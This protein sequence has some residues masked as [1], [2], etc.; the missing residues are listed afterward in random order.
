ML[1]IWSIGIDHLLLI[2]RLSTVIFR[3]NVDL[4]HPW[5]AGAART[6]TDL[7]AH[8]ATGDWVGDTVLVSQIFNDSLYHLNSGIGIEL[9]NQVVA[10]GAIREDGAN[11]YTTDGHICTRYPHLARC[12]ALI[13]DAKLILFPLLLG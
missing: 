8:L 12:R 9:H 3:R 1:I 2:E 13:T 11:R 7:N 4:H 6:I 5:G 10:I